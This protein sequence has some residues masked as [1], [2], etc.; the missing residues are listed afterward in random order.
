MV[1]GR[2]ADPQFTPLDPITKNLKVEG[3]SIKLTILPEIA[4]SG[5]DGLVKVDLNA[6]VD[7]SDLQRQLPTLMNKRWKYDEC[8]VR[9][10]THSAAVH[11]ADNG[12]LHVA[13]TAGAELWECVKTKFPETYS[14]VRKIGFAK[15]KLPWI[16][17]KMKTAKTKLLSQSIRI[18]ALARPVFTGD[19]VTADIKVT[20]AV[21]SGLLGKAVE[22]L[23][24]L[25]DLQAKFT[26]LVQREI[27]KMLSGQQFP[28]PKEFRDFNVVINSSKFID[29]GAA[30][31]GI[32][33]SASGS[34]TQAQ[35]AT[36]LNEQIGETR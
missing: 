28:L 4:V 10:S 17:W 15:I 19:T 26:E 13:V 32:E 27:G 14:K 36:L 29:R 22:M 16:R 20:Q 3:R 31:L 2:A 12:Q 18:E 23:D 11:P 25:L 5:S 24:D 7:A 8:G 6:L 34:I 30:S 21:P 35:L 9:T 33:L 1:K